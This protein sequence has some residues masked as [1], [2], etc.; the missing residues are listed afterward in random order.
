ML[1][2]TLNI[3]LIIADPI[4]RNL[5]YTQSTAFTGSFSSFS[6]HLAN[7][8]QLPSKKSFRPTAPEPSQPIGTLPG[9]L[10]V[11]SLGQ[12]LYN[13]PLVVPQ[14][15]AMT[16]SLSLSYNSAN[17]DNDALGLGFNLM[18]NGRSMSSA[19]TRGPGSKLLDGKYSRVKLT[20][21]DHYYLNGVRLIPVKG[22]SGANGTEYRTPTESYQKIISY[23]NLLGNS[24]NY[25]KIWYRD[26]SIS[27]YGQSSTSKQYI[28]KDFPGTLKKEAV[29]A[30]YLSKEQDSFKNT[31]LYQHSHPGNYH[32]SIV[33]LDKIIYDT[34][35]ATIT[36]PRKAEVRFSYE[37]KQRNFKQYSL[38]G[39]LKIG[40]KRIKN[41]TTHSLN[42]YGGLD[43]VRTY[44]ISYALPHPNNI[45]NFPERDRIT[46]FQV[47]DTKGVAFPATKFTWKGTDYSDGN[48]LLGTAPTPGGKTYLSYTEPSDNTPLDNQMDLEFH[49]KK[50]FTGDFNGDGKTDLWEIV[51][52]G[53]TSTQS[54]PDYDNIHLSNGDG[55]F[56]IKK[57]NFKTNG[58]THFTKKANSKVDNF[59]D[60]IYN[61]LLNTLFNDPSYIKAKKRS[62]RN[63]SSIQALNYNLDQCTDIAVLTPLA[64]KLRVQFYINDGNAG[65]STQ[66]THFDIHRPEGSANEIPYSIR[67]IDFNR[68]GYSDIYA[69]NMSG[70]LTGNKKDIIYLGGPNGFSHSPT[71]KL[72]GPDTGIR[73]GIFDD[74]RKQASNI[75]F[76]DVNQDGLMDVYK[77]REGKSD[78]VYINQDNGQFQVLHTF[79]PNDSFLDEY[80]DTYTDINGDGVMDI[81]SARGK[82]P[83]ASPTPGNIPNPTLEKSDLHFG[84]GQLNQSLFMQKQTIGPKFPIWYDKLH[85]QSE[86]AGIRTMDL[87]NDQLIDLFNTDRSL[88]LSTGENYMGFY[89]VLPMLDMS[90]YN[91]GSILPVDHN[92]DGISDIYFISSFSVIPPT[93]IPGGYSNG[94]WYQTINHTLH[95]NQTEHLEITKITNGLGYEID[96]EYKSLTEN[97]SDPVYLRHTPLPSGDPLPSQGQVNNSEEYHYLPR[98]RVVKSVHKSNGNGGKNKVSYRYEG[99]KAQKLYGD[100][101][102]N[103]VHSYDHEHRRHTKTSYLQKY[104]FIQKTLKVETYLMNQSSIGSF[105]SLL[106]KV[107]NSWS[108]SSS[109]S[110]ALDP[111][112]ISIELSST[113]KSEYSL[114]GD[115]RK[116]TKTDLTYDLYGNITKSIVNV[117]NGEKVTT[118]TSSFSPNLSNWILGLRQNDTTTTTVSKATAPIG[119]RHYS[120]STIYTDDPTTGALINKRKTRINRNTN[121]TFQPVTLT[122][123]NI[124]SPIGKMTKTTLNATGEAP[125]SNH[126]VYDSTGRY[127]IKTINPLGYTTKFSYEHAYGTIIET[128]DSNNICQW[129]NI[130]GFGRKVKMT[131]AI[132]TSTFTELKSSPVAAYLQRTYTSSGS[133]EQITHFD[134]LGRKI[135]NASES[136]L[137]KGKYKLQRTI[138]DNTGKVKQ[139]SV[140]YEGFNPN[141]LYGTM[142]TQNEYDMLGRIV[143]VTAP[144]GTQTRNLYH[145]LIR[146]GASAILNATL[147]PHGLINNNIFRTN[148]NIAL[149]AVTSI[150]TNNQ[151]ETK[152]S[153]T[154]GELW[155]VIDH[156]GNAIS[157]AYH[158]NGKM[159]ITEDALG[160]Q[161]TLKYDDN[162]NKITQSSPDLGVWHFY[163]DSL[164]Q[165][166]Q[167]IDAKGQITAQTYDL[168]G[169]VLSEQTPE[170]KTNYIYDKQVS[171]PNISLTGKLF[172]IT[173][174][175]AQGGTETITYNYNS[176]GATQATL[177][178]NKSGSFATGYVYDNQGRILEEWRPSTS[179]DPFDTTPAS[180]LILKKYYNNQGTLTEVKNKVT[181]YSYWKLENVDQAHRPNEIIFGNGLT[182]TRHYDQLR[183]WLSKVRTGHTTNI[184]NKINLS[185]NHD[186]IGNITRKDYNDDTGLILRYKYRFDNLNRLISET[187]GILNPNQQTV[188]PTEG[189]ATT[190]PKGISSPINVHSLQ[191]Y[192]HI[193][194]YS[195]AKQFHYDVIGNL[196]EKDGRIQRYGE[197]GAGPHALTNDGHSATT[198]TYDPNGNQL[199]GGGKYIQ[200]TSFNKPYRIAHQ[201]KNTSIQLHYAVN[202]QQRIRVEYSNRQEVSRIT[203]LGSYEKRV[204]IK[205]NQ[206][207]HRNRVMGILVHSISTDLSGFPVQTMLGPEG[208]G[209]RHSY[210]HKDHLGSILAITDDQQNII[211]QRELNAFGQQNV[212]RG[213]PKKSTDKGFT[214]HENIKSIE[215]VHMQARYYDPYT[216]RFISADTVIPDPT[217]LQSFNPYSYVR[218][219][220]VSLI[221]PDGHTWVYYDQ[222][223]NYGRHFVDDGDYDAMTY[224]SIPDN[225]EDRGKYIEE[226]FAAAK[227]K[228]AIGF[229]DGL[230]KS[231]D[232]AEKVIWAAWHLMGGPSLEQEMFI[233]EDYDGEHS[234]WVESIRG[235]DY[236]KGKLIR[237]PF[238]S[239]FT[240][241]FSVGESELGESFFE[242]PDQIEI[243]LVEE[244]QHYKDIKAIR[245]HIK[246]T[247]PDALHI[248]SNK[249][250]QNFIKKGTKGLIFT[251]S[252]TT[253]ELLHL[254]EI[255][256]KYQ[257][258]KYFK[259]LTAKGSRPQVNEFFEG[260]MNIEAQAFANIGSQIDLKFYYPLKN[261]FNSANDYFFK[262]LGTSQNEIDQQ[263]EYMG[264]Y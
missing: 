41:I 103:V 255:R 104:P 15:A 168:L 147:M 238:E 35:P 107:E 117:N 219:N 53:M 18:I 154:F 205:T 185:L 144:D 19:I 223:G 151:T 149:T 217:D 246:N 40:E 249:I 258:L 111:N 193:F 191:S 189:E 180:R 74:G 93:V 250:Y 176:Y 161:I 91:P 143:K 61:Y 20:T 125:R 184:G 229:D 58:V 212:L 261:S 201:K 199:T 92:G 120:A 37:K 9:K 137:V 60:D 175:D 77:K 102:F 263:I 171:F 162:G 173:G 254:I 7:L 208:N 109:M 14:G 24:P 259:N 192:N 75:F 215:L 39:I 211:E 62:A 105:E 166:V 82:R 236:M 134:L 253:D 22:S 44:K 167:S 79:S 71:H 118:V 115:L 130:D 3:G 29:K 30:W 126:M 145:N 70:I 153:D 25:F 67:F 133:P 48:G 129:V 72:Q 27:Y 6:T 113:T 241:G 200:W 156:D 222:N 230:L 248:V 83:K 150:N 202:K 260:Y 138:Y 69:F 55:S 139:V 56:T 237:M 42:Q 152:V 186:N 206:V 81:I 8:N 252:E 59:L 194:T 32:G 181:H 228:Y 52:K 207:E 234:I 66:P 87:N 114:D 96:L 98:E 226:K 108:K 247:S 221:D 86:L 165:L 132:G 240:I 64:K 158:A 1:F 140:P 148:T 57:S 119:A 73:W 84:H 131:N 227:G 16:P 47:F 128:C 135:L 209:S 198:Y 169:R 106:N 160:N 2:F 195:P 257:A 89:K 155:Q 232:M 172:Q 204:D 43:L 121:G 141:S 170:G 38:G 243:I 99:R 210:L 88:M 122:T 50:Y 142:W 174:P 196:I 95:I 203:T 239:E 187:Q 216:G 101:G 245:N 100:L 235:L 21:D 12:A 183:G 163:Y 190:N 13:I 164:G 90:L 182:E 231:S 213:D 159:T 45:N 224:M 10:T 242:S 146:G 23:G 197:N 256:G 63:I 28:V 220:P 54:T 218:N 264:R 26:G 225:V 17:K 11:G 123:Q 177:I 4:Y 94:R 188:A 36:V 110:Q 233:H 251:S 214:G 65:F 127:L 116:N 85:T 68:D 33:Q 78:I 244:I 34:N 124:Y 80:R 31:I 46:Q 76:T 97:D 179:S 157:Y 51:G 136:P 49:H 5:S 112:I 178:K 262:A